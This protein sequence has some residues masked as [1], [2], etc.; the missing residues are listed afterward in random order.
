MRCLRR[1]GRTASTFACIDRC[2]LNVK[3][4]TVN[5]SPSFP[6]SN[7]DRSHF[8]STFALFELTKRRG[9]GLGRTDCKLFPCVFGFEVVDRAQSSVNSQF[10][11]YVYILAKMYNNGNN[12]AW[13]TCKFGESTKQLTMPRWRCNKS[14]YVRIVAY[15]RVKML[16]EFD[17]AVWGFRSRMFHV[18]LLWRNMHFSTLMTMHNGVLHVTF[19]SLNVYVSCIDRYVVG[20]ARTGSTFV[21][22][23]IYALDWL[24]SC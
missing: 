23:A 11:V 17:N 20:R 4:S 13:P 9:V 12:D 16:V 14:M 22:L 8:W 6:L 24:W 3:L 18:C 19:A 7:Y 2:I 10:H 21:L 5:I 15:L 1:P